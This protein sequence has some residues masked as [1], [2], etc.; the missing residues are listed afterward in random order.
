[1]DYESE[2]LI[3]IVEL[4]PPCKK[5][6]PHP[7]WGRGGGL[8]IGRGGKRGGHKSPSGH[9]GGKRGSHSSGGHG[10]GGYR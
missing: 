6:D 8:V 7:W 2:K 1:M 10:G 4:N 9:P 3:K 5:N